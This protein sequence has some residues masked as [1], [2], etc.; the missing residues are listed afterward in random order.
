M[1]ASSTASVALWVAAE[2]AMSTNS[3]MRSQRAS[4]SLRSTS[5]W[6]AST[7]SPKKMSVSTM[8]ASHGSVVV[9]ESTA[10]VASSTSGRPSPCTRSTRAM[11]HTVAAAW[12]MITGQKF[13]RASAVTKRP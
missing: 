4:A 2:N 6:S 8:P 5:R 12:A 9:T 11:I 13:G 10:I 7:E 1:S 3:A